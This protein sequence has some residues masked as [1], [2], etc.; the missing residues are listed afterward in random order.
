LVAPIFQKSDE[1]ISYSETNL[2]TSDS[3]HAPVRA[4]TILHVPKISAGI[5]GGDQ[6]HSL[7][8]FATASCVA[9]TLIGIFVWTSW[10]SRQV[11]IAAAYDSSSSL[12]LSVKQFVA[13]SFETIDTG[14]DSVAEAVVAQRAKTPHEI[15]SL[16][17][18]RLK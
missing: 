17:A 1:R 5:G 7:W 12:T 16:L 6:R 9:A 14:F 2:V 18:A 8:L 13:R 3:R 10:T 15:Q 4:L 11:V